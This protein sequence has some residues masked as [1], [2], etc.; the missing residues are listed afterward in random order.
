MS[1][2]V[3]TCFDY[4]IGLSRTECDCLTDNIPMDASQS[5]SGIYLDELEGLNLNMV[6]GQNDCEGLWE[7]LERTRAEAIKI[8][9]SD[10]LACISANSTIRRKPF[11]GIMGEYFD[12]KALQKKKAYAGAV[13]QLANIS[14]GF[15]KVKRIGAKFDTTGTIDIDVYASHSDEV[16]D[17]LSLNTE[18]GKTIWTD[19]NFEVTDLKSSN[20]VNQRFYFIYQSSFKPYN[21]ASSCGCGINKPVW[22]ESSPCYSNGISYKDYGWASFAMLGGVTSETFDGA[23][24]D[25]AAKET[26]GLVFD[27]EIGCRNEKTI[28]KDGFDFT[29][30]PYAITIANAVRFKAGELLMLYIRSKAHPN[31]Y[32]LVIPEMMSELQERYKSEYENRIYN[33]LCPEL[34][35]AENI[36][37]YADCFACKDSYGFQ[38]TGI[39]K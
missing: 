18:A 39:I 2:Q 19:I 21:T 29:S 34:S 24:S 9:R 32:S 22:N 6:K 20:G 14:G 33:Y 5:E 28:C 16:I 4:I 8:T 13:I 15:L 3:D 26:Y 10:L 35:S 36:N 25:K 23:V 38:R 11:N 1:A 31:Y 12:A 30:D 17:T 7:L 37:R 27:V